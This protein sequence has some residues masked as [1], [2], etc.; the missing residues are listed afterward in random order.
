MLWQEA[1]E[2]IGQP[3][4][5]DINDIHEIMK[6]QIRGWRYVNKQRITGYGLQRCY[7]RIGKFLD[8]SGEIIPF[9]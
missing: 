1:L 3:K 4:Q 9:V 8:T 5:R 2:N 6:N 7:E